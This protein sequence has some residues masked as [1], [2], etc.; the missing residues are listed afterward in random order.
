MRR[1]EDCE[2][3]N[4]DQ[5]RWA[6][7]QQRVKSRKHR[8]EE[9]GGTIGTCCNHTHSECKSKRGAAK[10]KER[11]WMDM[12]ASLIR[13]PQGFKKTDKAGGAHCCSSVCACTMHLLESVECHTGRRRRRRRLKRRRETQCC[14]MSGNI[15]RHKRDGWRHIL[16]GGRHCCGFIHILSFPIRHCTYV[17][18]LSCVCFRCPFMFVRCCRFMGERPIER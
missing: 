14:G 7:Q 6:E 12:M 5:E 3:T 16:Q 2:K 15:H 4:R 1:Q 13:V 9:Q 17:V 11:N 10:G 18:E 8:D